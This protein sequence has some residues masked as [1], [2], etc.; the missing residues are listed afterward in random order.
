MTIKLTDEEIKELFNSACY[1]YFCDTQ[2][3]I[4]ARAPFAYLT[5]LTTLF[6]ELPSFGWD[7]IGKQL[8]NQ[9]IRYDALGSKRRKTG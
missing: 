7:C 4:S 3:G 9:G 5:I 8:Y 2:G 1:R 6:L